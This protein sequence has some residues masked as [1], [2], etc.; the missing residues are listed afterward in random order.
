MVGAVVVSWG[1]AFLSKTKRLK[2]DMVGAVVA[3]KLLDQL[4]AKVNGL[5]GSITQHIIDLL[6][7]FSV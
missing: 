4:A 5:V 2:G 3:L 1:I 7:E 6:H